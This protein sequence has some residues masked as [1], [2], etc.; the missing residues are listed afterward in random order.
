MVLSAATVM[1]AEMKTW[2]STLEVGLG[3]CNIYLL[4]VHRAI[5]TYG[6]ANRCNTSSGRN[7]AESALTG[8]NTITTS[9]CD[10]HS[11]GLL[12]SATVDWMICND[13]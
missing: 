7:D 9:G 1:L 11:S 8:V 3:K 6:L 10:G 12:R 2:K 13:M 4:V 5:D